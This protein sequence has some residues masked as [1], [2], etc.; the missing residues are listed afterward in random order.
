MSYVF[1]NPGLRALL[2]E[3]LQEMDGAPFIRN[4]R[5]CVR[6]VHQPFQALALCN[7]FAWPAYRYKSVGR[8]QLDLLCQMIEQA[9]AVEII[10]ANEDFDQDF[11]L[12]CQQLMT[13]DILVYSSGKGFHHAGIADMESQPWGLWDCLDEVRRRWL[14]D[15]SYTKRFYRAYRFT[16]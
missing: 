4:R 2:V 6:F 8:T 12:D 3:H 16:T 14:Q 9:A 11:E 1:E 10:V 13:G 15:P 5:D 7:E